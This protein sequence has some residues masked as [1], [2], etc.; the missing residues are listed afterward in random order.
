MLIVLSAFHLSY[1]LSSRIVLIAPAVSLTLIVMFFL[2]MTSADFLLNHSQKVMV[3]VGWSFLEIQ[4][5]TRQQIHKESPDN[6]FAQ[7]YH[8]Y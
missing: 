1:P 3:L 4:T 5:D 6:N 7:R 2:L 8:L